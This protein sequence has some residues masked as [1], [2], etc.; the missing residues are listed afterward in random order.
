MSQIHKCKDGTED[1]TD[2]GTPNKIPCLN[3]GG[4]VGK[5]TMAGVGGF[6]EE[7]WAWIL[8]VIGAFW[9]GRLSK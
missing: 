6:Y 3:R 7:Y 1:V 8:I 4:E 9:M 2:K 5:V